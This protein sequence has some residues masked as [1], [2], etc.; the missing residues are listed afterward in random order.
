MLANFLSPDVQRVKDSG[1]IDV[2]VSNIWRRRNVL[3]DPVT[4]KVINGVCFE[5]I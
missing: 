3:F 2:P 5:E 1:D 4:K